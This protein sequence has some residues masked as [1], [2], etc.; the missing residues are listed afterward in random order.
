MSYTHLRDSQPKARKDHKCTWC[1]KLIPKGTIYNYSSGVF[2]G[3]FCTSHLHDECLKAQQKSYNRREIS[4]DEGYEPYAQKR[5]LTIGESEDLPVE[6]HV[7]PLTK[8][9]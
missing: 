8:A 1:G 7:R 5:G 9:L 2:D 3:S 6:N 4:F